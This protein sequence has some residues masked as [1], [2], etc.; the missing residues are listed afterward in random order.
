MSNLTPEDRHILARNIL[1]F[2]LKLR[3]RQEDDW[4]ENC[5]SQSS[6]SFSAVKLLECDLRIFRR[7]LVR[8]YEFDA[9]PPASLSSLSD[10][11][12]RLQLRVK[13]VHASAPRA[14]IRSRARSLHVS[15]EHSAI[16]WRR[17]STA[18]ALFRQRACAT[19][20]RPT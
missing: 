10:R 5:C 13:H 16:V 7:T 8:L 6:C 19:W 2:F 17:P 12:L 1:A 3:E 11:K 14:R 9:K 20:F 15:D 4:Q 18:F